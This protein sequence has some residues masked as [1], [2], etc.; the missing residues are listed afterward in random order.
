[1]EEKLK[2]LEDITYDEWGVIKFLVDE[3]FDEEKLKN[4][5]KCDENVLKRLKNFTCL[6]KHLVVPK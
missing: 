5:F 3:K 1:M 6:K 4:T 2:A